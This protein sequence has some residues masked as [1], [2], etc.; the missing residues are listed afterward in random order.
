MVWIAINPPDTGEYDVQQLDPAQEDRFQ[1]HFFV[2]NRPDDEYFTRKYM[3]KGVK[4]TNWWAKLAPEAQKKISPRRLD[5]AAEMYFDGGDLADVLPAG[6]NTAE[7]IEVLGHGTIEER[8]NLLRNNKNTT[9]EDIRR[10]IQNDNNF[11]HLKTRLQEK[12]G[13]GLEIFKYF[14]PHIE[15]E[16]AVSICAGNT[17]ML[18]NFIFNAG[19]CPETIET[20]KKHSDK[21]DIFINLFK[22]TIVNN[23]TSLMGESAKIYKEEHITA[24][25]GKMA[26]ELQQSNFDNKNQ[27][28]G[29]AWLLQYVRDNFSGSYTGTPVT[30]FKTTLLPALDRHGLRKYFNL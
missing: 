5:Y 19:L 7:L 6:I 1:V 23:F 24:V 12:K 25:L 15:P 28:Y 4:F 8:Y 29:A 13:E 3:E 22:G 9:P 20:L 17:K 11:Q 18:D 30:K 16:R 26:T 10:F 2:P 27:V 21:K 14:A